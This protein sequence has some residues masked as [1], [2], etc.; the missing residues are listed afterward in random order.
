MFGN[1]VTRE[2]PRPNEKFS[3]CV[4]TRTRLDPGFCAIKRHKSKDFQKLSGKKC[5]NWCTSVGDLELAFSVRGD[6]AHG[7]E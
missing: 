7:S 5:S 6:D 3:P 4:S 2:P 1:L